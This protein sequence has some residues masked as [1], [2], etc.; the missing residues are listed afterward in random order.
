MLNTLKLLRILFRAESS[1]NTLRHHKQLERK[2]ETIGT[3]R[4]PEDHLNN[5]QTN[6]ISYL[7]EH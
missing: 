7:T 6:P 5:K 4:F 3:L 1:R 2:K